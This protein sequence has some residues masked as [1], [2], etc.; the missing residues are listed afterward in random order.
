THS[1]CNLYT[2]QSKSSPD[3]GSGFSVV[4]LLDDEQID[5]YSSISTD[6]DGTRTPKQDW[7]R[8][9]KESEWK[10]ST[11]KLRD[12]GQWLNL[13]FDQ[14][15]K[16]FEHDESDGHTLQWRIGCEGGESSDGSVLVINY[17][18]EYGYDGEDFISYNWTLKK[19]T[20]SVSQAKNMEEV[21]NQRPNN[22]KCEECVVW[23]KIYLQYSTSETNQ[24]PPDVHVF[25]KKPKSNSNKLTLSCLATGFYPKDVVV[26]LRK[27]NTSLPEHLLTSSG[28]RPNEDGTYQLRKSV[29]IQKDH[30]ADYDCYVTH[31]SLKESII[32]K[33]VPPVSQSFLGLT[34]VAVASAFMLV[35]VIVFILKKNQKTGIS[36]LKN[37]KV[38]VT[39]PTS[40]KVRWKKVLEDADRY[41]LLASLS[42][43]DGSSRLRQQI[44]VSSEEDSAVIDHLEPGCLY[45]ISLIG[46]KDST[47]SQPATVHAATRISGPPKKVVTTTRTSVK[48]QWEKSPGQ[49][50]K[51]ILFV[52]TSP[53]TE[54]SFGED[55]A[56]TDHLEHRC[57]CNIS[58]FAEKDG[59]WNLLATNQGT[60]VT[61]LFNPL[62]MTTL[63]NRGLNQ[64]SSVRL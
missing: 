20:A 7:L 15:I 18:N 49:T 28:V 64:V 36:N 2:I 12:D 30:T 37:L 61:K 56:E 27:L 34:I 60:S 25:V 48:V 32:T 23:L 44:K 59:A 11:D 62:K 33:L 54:V 50:D 52:S 39:S 17:I 35:G 40:V 53:K 55:S 1:L 38:V 26:R 41:I 43:A 29:E 4:T 21:W 13:V 14:Q 16:V 5:S 45:V 10:E 42:Q 31:S 47:Q 6:K 9:L 46:D 19:W 51:Y 63:K 3:R 8:K 24:I 58:L 22:R 57:L